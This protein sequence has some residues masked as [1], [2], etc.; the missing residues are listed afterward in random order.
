VV[1]IL[2]YEMNKGKTY[3]KDIDKIMFQVNIKCQLLDED[4]LLYFEDVSFTQD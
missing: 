2:L 4:L 1:N 3:I